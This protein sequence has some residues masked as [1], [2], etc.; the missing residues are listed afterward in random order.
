MKYFIGFGLGVTMTISMLYDYFSIFCMT[1]FISLI[2]AASVS[3][4]FW[5]DVDAK[6]G[7]T[8][9]NSRTRR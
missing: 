9:A 3:K 1:L 4:C 2:F 7:T 6:K 5:N 8:A